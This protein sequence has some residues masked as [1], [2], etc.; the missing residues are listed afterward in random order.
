MFALSISACD[1]D[2]DDDDAYT[3]CGCWQVPRSIQAADIVDDNK[4]RRCDG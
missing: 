4:N 1:D 3:G 2:D